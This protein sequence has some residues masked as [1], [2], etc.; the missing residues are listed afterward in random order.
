[1]ASIFRQKYTVKGE[2]GKTVR[3]QSKHWY[4]DYKTADGTRKRVK[5]FKDKQATAQLAAKLEK[6]A[7]QAQV[8]IVDKYKEH[9]RRPLAQHLEDFKQSLLA[10]GNT[11]Q[12]VD[13]TIARIEPVFVGCRVLFWDDI[14]ASS[15]EE[16]LAGLRDKE[17]GISTQTSNYYLQSVKQF[18]RWIVR[19]Q[20]A[21]ESPVAHLSKVTVKASPKTRRA[22]EPDQLRRLLEVTQTGPKRLNMT[23]CERAML[24]RLAAETGL[25]ANELRS[26]TMSSFDFEND[27]VCL[28]SEDAKNSKRAEIPIRNETAVI[29]RAFLSGK[30]P[31]TK[32]FPMPSKYNMADMLRKDCEAAGIETEDDGRGKIDFHSLRHTTGSLLAAAGVQPKVAQAIMRHSDINLTMSRYTHIFLG[33]ASE[34]VEKLPDLSLPSKENQKRATGTDGLPVDGA[35]KPAYKKS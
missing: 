10:K 5:G 7:E 12:Y 35:Y 15:V 27:V 14:S 32:A 18:C 6:E 4:I 9:R 21:S 20:R 26:L 24:Y 30:L 29:L 31:E 33:Q 19:D 1:M 8:G 34:A 28:R 17:S 23:G 2:S 11:K 25:R 3:K 22:L 16:Y 13:Q